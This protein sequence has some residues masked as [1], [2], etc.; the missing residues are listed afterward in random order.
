MKRATTVAILI[1]ITSFRA[2]SQTATVG[3]DSVT[4]VA[5]PDFAA[6]GFHRWLLGDNYREEWTTP[7][8]VPVLDLHSFAGGLK[9][10]EKGGGA[11][12]VSL[13][14]IAPDSTE[15]AFRSIQKRVGVLSKQYEGTVIYYIFKD[16]G[17]ASHPASFLAAEPMEDAAEV[18]HPTGRLA[19]MPDD[20]ILGDFRK[21]FAGMLGEIEQRPTVPKDGPAFAGASKIIGAEELLKDINSNPYDQVDPRKM[22]NARLLDMVFGDNDRH[23]DQWKW[24]RFGKKDDPP[25]VPIATDRDKVFVSYRG[26]LMSLARKAL[27]NLVTFDSTYPSPTALFNNATD[28][29]RRMLAG[30]DRSVWDSV[31]TALTN[32]LTNSVIDS[33]MRSMPHEYAPSSRVIGEKVKARRDGLRA[34]ADH[35]YDILS[36]VVDIHATDSADKA[37]VVRSAD[38]IVDVQIQYGNNPPWFNRRFKAAETNEIRL[39]LHGGDDNATVTGNVRSSIPVRIIGGNGNNTLVDQSVVGGNRNPTRLYDVGTVTDNVYKP[40]SIDIHANVDNALNH[41]FNRRPWLHA[42]GTLIP[43]QRDYGSSTRPYAGVRTGRNL[44]IVT[45]VGATRYVYGFRDVPYSSMMLGQVGIST[46]GRYAVILGGDKRFESSQVHIPVDASV[47]QLEQVEF[48]GFG[49]DVPDLRGKPY[50]VKQTQFSF[51]PAIGF[52]INQLSDISVGP[53]VRYTSTDSLVGSVAN[54]NVGS[55]IAGAR[56]YGFPHFGQAGGQ[57]KFH[58]DSR[59]APLPDTMRSRV[60]VDIVG[61]GYP[62]AWDVKN[63]YES[64]SGAAEGFFTLPAKNR[65]VLALRAGGKKLFGDFPYFDAAYVG[66]SSS[67]RTEE[68]QRYAGDASLYGTTE[69][70]VPVAKFPLI[71][72]LDVGLIGFL[73]IAKVYVDGDSPG[74]W[75]KG[76]GGGFWVGVLNPGT[77]VNV[78]FTNNP[79]R[80]VISSFGFAF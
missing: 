32:E 11:Q 41:S 22:L 16:E 44:G 13:R 76:T 75:H 39:Y 52:S 18:L 15:W 49:N 10:L 29:D 36:R 24:A 63:T 51:R 37:T 65:P 55:F 43:P 56:P 60:V 62:S 69:L 48:R 19:V 47:T 4:I 20:P 31:A 45:K 57:I 61:S 38:G 6:G 80:R 12:T 40:D 27:P 34:A 21:E 54:N 66:G 53:I 79:N 59:Y 5:G 2:Q 28:F 78:L 33:A 67:L 42:Y 74:G 17:S 71:L 7:I 77:S 23:P 26:A 68:R 3:R 35:Y 25:W 64:L 70:R 8:K 1:A 50:E 30:L 14:F 9:P 46:T 58:F 72:P 73:D